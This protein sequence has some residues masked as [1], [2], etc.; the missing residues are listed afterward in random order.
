MEKDRY[1][2]P[3][4]LMVAVSFSLGIEVLQWSLTQL[5]GQDY[6]NFDVDDILL[7][8]TGYLLGYLILRFSVPI[9]KNVV[10]VKHL[11]KPKTVH[12]SS[13]R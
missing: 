11:P 13:S 2:G 5:I 1:T 10:D 8:V 9:L 12:E 6:R 3:K 4:A 7:N